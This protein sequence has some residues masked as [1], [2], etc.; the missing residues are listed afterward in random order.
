MWKAEVMN[1]IE[2]IGRRCKIVTIVHR[3]YTIERSDCIYEFKD[4][5]IVSFGNYQQLLKQSKPFYMVEIAKRTYESN[6]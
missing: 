4:E 3:L 5:E 6:I 1:A 2:I